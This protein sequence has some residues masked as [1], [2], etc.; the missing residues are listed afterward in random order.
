MFSRKEISLVVA[1]KK[2]GSVNA[3]IYCTLQDKNGK[4]LGTTIDTPNA[5]AYAMAVND[6]V[7]KSVAHY[8]LFGES[9]HTREEYA[10]RFSWVVK[11]KNIHE[12]YLKWN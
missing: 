8:P 7:V 6:K 1:M 12:Q 2:I 3:A 5:I 9:V 11:E 10:D 4:V